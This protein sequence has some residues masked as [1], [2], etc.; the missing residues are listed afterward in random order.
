V[1]GGKAKGRRAKR[2]DRAG[3]WGPTRTEQC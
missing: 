1:S 3:G 2:V